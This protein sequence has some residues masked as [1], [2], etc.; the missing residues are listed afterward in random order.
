MC[1]GGVCLLTLLASR[2]SFISEMEHMLSSSLY[3]SNLR[4]CIQIK[5]VTK[6]TGF[7]NKNALECLFAVRKY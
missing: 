6:Y 4:F 3:M 2:L 7:T 5:V 1:V